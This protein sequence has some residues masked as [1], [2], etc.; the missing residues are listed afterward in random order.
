[1]RFLFSS[2]LV[3]MAGAAPLASPAQASMVYAEP[4]SSAPTDSFS[5][6]LS[7]GSLGA[8][9]FDGFRTL[10]G[11]NFYIDY[12]SPNSRPAFP[13]AFSVAGGSNSQAFGATSSYP[14]NNGAVIGFGGGRE[15]FGPGSG[16]SKESSNFGFDGGRGSSFGGGALNGLN[17]LS[18][19]FAS[20]GENRMDDRGGGGEKAAVSATPLPST[21]TMM[22]I[23]FGCFGLIAQRLRKKKKNEKN[24]AV[25]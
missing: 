5:L 18:F 12:S 24:F 1:M 16:G 15:G 10:D 11:K 13:G 8:A 21:W 14:G 4:T 20:L 22:L 19:A 9:I 17:P 25:A 7:A 3:A 23:G 6:K 2:I